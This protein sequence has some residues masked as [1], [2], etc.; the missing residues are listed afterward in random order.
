MDSLWFGLVG[1]LAG[2]L[3][4]GWIFSG[5][6]AVPY[7]TALA[8]VLKEVRSGGVRTGVAGEPEEVGELREALAAGWAPRTPEVLEGGGE[9]VLRRVM[10]YLKEQVAAPLSRGLE[11]DGDLTVRAME[12][13]DAVEDLGFFAEVRSVGDQAG[14]VLTRPIQEVV[15]EYTAE[16]GIPIRLR[17]PD[18][19]PRA[20][21]DAEAFKDALYLLLVNAGRY[22]GKE[23]VEVTL[24]G[25]GSEVRI[26]IRDRGPGFTPEALERAMEPFYST[27]EGALGMGLTHARQVVLAHGGEIRLRNRDGGGGEVEVAIPRG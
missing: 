25:E 3:A 16:F 13:L 26:L 10:G 24:E 15:R 12:A 6:A 7:R 8:S 14:E 17:L 19:S 21:L 18:S 11:G 5:R 27:E 22:G 23:P 2:G 20:R 4:V 9:T 1:G